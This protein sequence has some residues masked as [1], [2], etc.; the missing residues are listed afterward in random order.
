MYPLR[1]VWFLVV[2]GTIAS[3]DDYDDIV[4]WGKAHLAFLR[5]CR[6]SFRHSVAAG[7]KGMGSPSHL[8]RGD[9]RRP[10]PISRSWELLEVVSRPK[11][12]PETIKPRK[13]ITRA[14]RQN[15]P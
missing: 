4:D 2:C 5:L 10:F 8:R 1:E 3:G 11:G 14:F 6:I 13:I 12:H 15:L 9:P 7:C